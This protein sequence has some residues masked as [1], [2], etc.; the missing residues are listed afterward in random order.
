MAW[1][2]HT[3]ITPTTRRLQ[4]R[5][6]LRPALFCGPYI[7]S[8]PIYWGGRVADLLR[9]SGLIADLLRFGGLIADR[10]RFDDPAVR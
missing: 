5:V 9:F 7:Y 1:P 6:A 2:Q 3:E 4:P 8:L 10:L